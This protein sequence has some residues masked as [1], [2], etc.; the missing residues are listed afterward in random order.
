MDSGRFES[1]SKPYAFHQAMHSLFVPLRLATNA[2]GLQLITDLDRRIDRV[3]CAAAG[4]RVGDGEGV[5]V[6][7]EMRLRQVLTNLA[8]NACKFTPAGG[9]LRISTRLLWPTVEVD[10]HVGLESGS[11]RTEA[12]KVPSPSPGG[13]SPLPS[14]SQSRG[15]ESRDGRKAGV[16]SAAIL[17]QHNQ[18]ETA[19]SRIIVRI[20][21][22]D[23]GCGI[24]SK[25]MVH[26]KLFCEYT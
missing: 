9:S 1:V 26:N 3:A 6:G 2:R 21:V 24:Q 16:L 22:S 25:D 15:K 13:G 8:S 4:R 23:T 12:T 18:D 17:K 19:L 7:D 11:E 14:R 20:E 10:G 5:V